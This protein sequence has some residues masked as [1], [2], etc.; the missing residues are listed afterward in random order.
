MGEH[1]VQVLDGDQIRQG[2][3]DPGGPTPRSGPS[4]HAKAPALA[5]Q[6]AGQGL[7]SPNLR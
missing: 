7:H 1:A 5:P 2:P 3:R 6:Q 4:A